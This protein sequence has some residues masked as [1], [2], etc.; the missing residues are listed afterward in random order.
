M[1]YYYIADV[2]IKADKL[3]EYHNHWI[4]AGPQHHEEYG[5]EHIATFNV[6]AGPEHTTH[7]KRLFKITDI[8]AWARG[9]VHFSDHKQYWASLCDFVRCTLLSP[10][11]YSPMK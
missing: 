8:E 5:A 9:E 10:E 7:V 3:R 2:A 1:S 6:L 11:D 4:K